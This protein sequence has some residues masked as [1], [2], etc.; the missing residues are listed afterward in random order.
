MITEDG[1]QWT[2]SRDTPWRC[3]LLQ[4]PKRKLSGRASVRRT[5]HTA[6]ATGVR[7]KCSPDAFSGVQVSESNRVSAGLAAKQ[8]PSG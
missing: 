4:S 7:R 6:L 8:S 5:P 2:V 1:R 3:P